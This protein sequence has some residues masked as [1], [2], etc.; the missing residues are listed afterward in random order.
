MGP[1]VRALLD[2]HALLWWLESPGRLSRAARRAI[3]DQA[4]T[5]MVSAATAWE[6]AIKSRAGKLE[7]GP[8]VADF[9]GELEEEGFAE[10]AISAGHATRAG[11]L[12]GPLRDPFD[13]MLI[14]Q[15]QAENLSIISK[16]K[17]FD[18]YAVQRIW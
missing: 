4:T 15:A 7:A 1:R 11:L 5:V 14:A 9:T 6:I 10:L 18:G 17:W 8:L 3:E 13:R 16:D 2:T 12:G